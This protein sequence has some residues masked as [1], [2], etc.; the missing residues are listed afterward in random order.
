MYVI[1]SAIGLDDEQLS[2]EEHFLHFVFGRL[3]ALDTHS[4]FEDRPYG[5]IAID[6]QAGSRI[7][8]LPLY[9][10]GTI[11]RHSSQVQHRTGRNGIEVDILLYLDIAV[12]CLQ[13]DGIYLAQI[14]LD[15]E[16]LP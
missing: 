8:I 5:D 2:V 9:E 11:Q 3:N 14:S 6:G 10:T 13:S 15:E 12:V 4:R 1:N 16:F 7:I